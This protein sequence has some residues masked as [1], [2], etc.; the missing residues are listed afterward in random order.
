[1]LDVSMGYRA[2]LAGSVPTQSAVGRPIGV[3]VATEALRPVRVNSRWIARADHLCSQ[4]SLDQD[5]QLGIACGTLARSARA[6]PHPTHRTEPSS[7]TSTAG[8]S[9][10]RL[11]HG[12]PNDAH[13]GAPDGGGLWE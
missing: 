9:R 1:M 13:T 10:H 5:D 8:R 4:R 7:S 12:R 3:D 2:G 11:R 6:P